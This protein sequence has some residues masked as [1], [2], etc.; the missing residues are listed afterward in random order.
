MRASWI[1]GQI[2]SRF[3]MVVVLER[4]KPGTE[5]LARVRC[6]CG[7]VKDVSIDNLRNG[8]VSSCGCK[9]GGRTHDMSGTPEYAVWNAMLQRCSN[10]RHKKWKDYGGRGIRVCERWL[11]FENFIADVGR[12][13]APHLELDRADNDGDY[14]PHNCRWIS[15]RDQTNNTRRNVFIEFGGERLTIAQWASRLGIPRRTIAYRHA[16]GATAEVALSKSTFQGRRSDLE[17]LKFRQLEKS[18]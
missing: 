17:R 11:Q 5:S 6:D 3:G 15:R 10:P 14:A 16:K 12:R 4:I 8:R 18:Q 1:D 13:P 7:T 9:Q 2:G